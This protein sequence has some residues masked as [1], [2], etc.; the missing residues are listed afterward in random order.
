[1]REGR[2]YLIAKVLPHNGPKAGDGIHFAIDCERLNVFDIE[3]RGGHSIT[4]PAASR[5]RTICDLV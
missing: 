3:I 1:M 4:D 2:E 5:G